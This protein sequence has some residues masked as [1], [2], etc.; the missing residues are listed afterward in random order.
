M[1]MLKADNLIS[2]RIR[3][4]LPDSFK[5]CAYQS[6]K[7]GDVKTIVEV[8][9]STYEVMTRDKNGRVIYDDNGIAVPRVGRDGKVILNTSAYMR[10][11]D[12]T[13]S[14]IKYRTAVN[15][16]ISLTGDFEKEVGTAVFDGFMPCKVRI[17]PSKDTYGDVER[18]T[19]AFDPIDD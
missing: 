5:G 6:L 16:L 17:I 11:D 9:Y 8:V 13:M 7:V 14:S 4:I 3:A 10:F 12:G 19:I 18:D 2:D 1:P 15:Q